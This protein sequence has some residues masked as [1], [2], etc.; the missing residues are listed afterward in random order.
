MNINESIDKH[1]VLTEQ[2]KKLKEED[3]E[4]KKDIKLFMRTNGE[5]KYEGDNGIISYKE[6]TRNTLDKKKV[7]E[8]ITEEQF[9]EC[10]KTSTFD[11]L[12]IISNESLDKMKKHL[13][14]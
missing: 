12:K 13:K 7:Q 8:F 5:E 11:V 14:K 3:D 9:N 6:N 1:F 10:M 2:I 4:I